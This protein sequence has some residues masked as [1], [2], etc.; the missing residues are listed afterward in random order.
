MFHWQQQQ[1]Q[2][3]F[4]SDLNDNDVGPYVNE[5]EKAQWGWNWLERWMSSQPFH[6]RNTGHQETPYMA[7]PTTTAT[8]TTTTVTDDVSE[9]TVEMD[10]HAH[11]ML[12]RDSP[13]SG[14][15]LTKQR[16][17]S[18]NNVPSYMAPTQS[19]KAKVRNQGSSKQLS[20]N[21]PQWNP[22]TRRV[23]VAESGCDSTSSGGGTATYQAPRSP[24]P[25]NNGSRLQA[26]RPTGCS[27]N[28]HGPDDWPLA[29]HAWRHDF[30]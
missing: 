6:A 21:V 3:L 27:P 23:S 29:G 11:S 8:T 12:N 5:H 16:Q 17:V 15:Y 22:S 18:S 25:K 13:E 1:Q 10:I 24:S 9:K 2:Q 28:S 26:R 7:L 20:L 30:G 19:A 14:P 4:R